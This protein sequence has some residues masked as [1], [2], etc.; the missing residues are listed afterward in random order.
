MVLNLP[1]L[2]TLL[3]IF[4][5][6]LLI[7]AFYMPDWIA[8]DSTATYWLVQWS[9]VICAG[10]FTLAAITDAL[11]GYAARRFKQVTR[12]GA[13]IDPIADKMIIAVALLL[14]VEKTSNWV[15]TLPAMVIITREFAIAGLRE[16]IVGE[17]YSGLVAVN[18]FGKIKTV[19]QSLA[20][21]FLLWGINPEAYLPGR[22]IWNTGLFLL[23][24]A[25][26]MTLLS[27]IIYF[28]R[29]RHTLSR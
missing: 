28:V 2:L 10:L 25:A 12:F 4:I 24:L 3:R 5:I 27:M 22:F 23:Y 9:A 18:W 8:P 19:I 14:V 20:I 17:G 21:I 16:W 15:I 29:A 11:D 7:V 1:T 26:V 6:P 13:L